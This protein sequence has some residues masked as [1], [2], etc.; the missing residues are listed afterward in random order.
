MEGLRKSCSGLGV[1]GPG[2]R[3]CKWLVQDRGVES[4]NGGAKEVLQWLG[5]GIFI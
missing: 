3:C 1:V 5:C 2:L 4:V